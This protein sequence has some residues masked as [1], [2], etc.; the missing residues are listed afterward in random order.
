M[1]KYLIHYKKKSNEDFFST[2]AHFA[3]AFQNIRYPSEISHFLNIKDS[4]LQEP[5]RLG[6][7]AI[8]LPQEPGFSV[9]VDE[10]KLKRYRVDI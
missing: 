10:D 9:K 4:L 7:G 5:I 3:A 6:D 2:S 1:S 8:E